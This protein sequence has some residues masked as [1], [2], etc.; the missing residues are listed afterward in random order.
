MNADKQIPELNDGPA[1]KNL[2]FTVPESY[3]DELPGRIQE[4]LAGNRGR[5]RLKPHPVFRPSLAIAAMFVGL[6]AIGYAGFRILSHHGNAPYLSEKELDET[7]EYFAYDLDDDMLV[8]TL[9]ESGISLSP[10]PTD[11]RTEEIIQVLS[12]E[13]LNVNDL[14]SE[15]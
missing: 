5:K 14:I 4:R 1:L 6:V 2:P 3:F 8:S 13:D 7:M 10:K 12:Q 15:N 9:V 11:Q